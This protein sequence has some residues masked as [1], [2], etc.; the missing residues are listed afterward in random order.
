MRQLIERLE[1]LMDGLVL[2]PGQVFVKAGSHRAFDAVKS[3]L[4]QAPQTYYLSLTVV[5]R[6]KGS[7]F[8][9]SQDE[10]S[11]IAGIKG[12]TKARLKDSWHPTI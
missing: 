10:F 1:G 7:H 6:P 12:V 3:K 9:V 2:K 8:V 4:G 11:Q 5:K